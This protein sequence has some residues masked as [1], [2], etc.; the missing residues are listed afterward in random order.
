MFGDAMIPMACFLRVAGSFFSG[1]PRTYLGTL[2]PPES[3]IHWLAS[4]VFEISSVSSDGVYL[5]TETEVDGGSQ[6]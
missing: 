1:F 5:P 2:G 3:L 4:L 6:R